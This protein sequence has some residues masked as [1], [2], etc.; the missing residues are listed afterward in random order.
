MTAGL[1][2]SGL[3]RALSPSACA[4]NPAIGYWDPLNLALLNFW[5]QGEDA[6]VVRSSDRK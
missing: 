1:A 2:A 6:T 5:G 3:K 4:Q